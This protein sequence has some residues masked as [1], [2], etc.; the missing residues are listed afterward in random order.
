MKRSDYSDWNCSVARTMGV[1]GDRWTMLV[2]REAFFGVRRFDEIQR[3]L[4]VARNV[5]SERLGRL[6]DHEILER[7]RYQ[8]HPE[9]FEYRLTHKGLDLYAPLVALM[10]WGDEHMAGP[11]GPPV[12]LTHLTCG[13]R[14]DPTLSCSHC[15]EALDPR[16]T[17][18]E[19]GPG[20][21]VA[22]P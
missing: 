19:R 22:R 12:E 8:A 6:V 4:G 3:N 13:H 2:L 21:T 15:G 18:P 1:V 10:R 17:R 7:R 11:E 14:T 16:E 20:A 9:R 5:L